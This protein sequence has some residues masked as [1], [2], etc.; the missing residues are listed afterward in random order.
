[1]MTYYTLIS[2]VLLISLVLMLADTW[3]RLAHSEHKT[4]SVILVLATIFY[5]LLDLIWVQLYMAEDY[6]R[7]ALAVTSVLFYFIYI[8]LPYIWFLF[9][10]HFASNI[11]KNKKWM[12]ILSIPWFVNLAL[13]ILTALGTDVLWAVGDS[14]NRYVRGPLFGLFANL[15]LLYYFIPVVEILILMIRK[16]NG[17]SPLLL[18]T[19]GFAVVPAMSVFIHTY[20]I[21]VDAVIPFQPS[22]FFIGVMCAY[23]L[24]ITTTYKETEEQNVR[25]TERA[26]SAERIAELSKSV[27]TLLTNMPAMTFSKD[28]ETG[29]YL[30]CNQSFADYAH[31]ETPEGVAGL[32]DAE[33]FDPVTAAHF[34]EDDHMALSMDE[35]YVFYEDVPDAAG[36]PRQFQTT[37]LKFVDPDGRLCLLGMCADVTD[38]V[39]IRRGEA[40]TKEAYDKAR[41]NGIIYTHIAESLA[42]G[43]TDLYYVDLETGEFTEY[44]AAHEGSGLTEV[45]HGRDFF[46][47]CKNVAESIVFLDDRVAFS[48]AMERDALLEAL[49]R[50]DAFVMT[51]R[52][53]MNGKPVYVSMRV[54]SMKDDRRFIVVGVTDVDKQMKQRRAEEQM[55]EE[56]VIYARLQALTGNFMFIYVV[57]PETNHYRE[58]SENNNYIE[59]FAQAKEGTDFFTVLREAAQTYNYPED[60]NRFLSVFTKENVLAEIEQSGIFTLSNRLVIDGDPVHVQIKAAMVEETEGRRL[61]VGIN[62]VDAQVRQEEEYGKRLEKAQAEASIDALTGVKNKHAYL[63]VETRM[64]LDISERRQV[65]F[66]I[67]MLDVNDLKI[68]NDTAGHNAGDQ[69]LRDACKIICDT[70]KHSPVF[71]VGGDE[72][73]V[74]AQGSDYENIE[75]LIGNV[76]GYNE[77]AS[78]IGGIIIACGMSRFANDACV[79]SV[80]ERADHEMYEN[81]AQLK[82]REASPK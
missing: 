45:R 34:V 39:S 74:I 58:F 33:I 54:S 30:A 69:Y 32:T 8:T 17:K 14:D 12:I 37:K 47:F 51:Y 72:F 40:T 2:T 42:H 76:R 1:M 10:H 59:S 77:E 36:N 43:Y 23:A 26:L 11:N 22:C 19:F 65:P 6:Q 70:F 57:D 81:K 61:I 62:D 24:L 66:A 67:V 52:R 38:I 21:P 5:V 79:A 71:R 35:P 75:E 3:S 18:R 55:K 68:V 63:E 28:V 73:V 50:D 53:L 78:A 31:K 29:K 15:N 25:L 49:N 4:I 56:R 13:V 41:R 27:S 44:E 64:D 46:E 48:K 16:P 9:S 7:E 80:F 82:S 60:L 20:I